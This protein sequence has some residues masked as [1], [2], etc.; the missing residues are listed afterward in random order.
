MYKISNSYNFISSITHILQRENKINQRIYNVGKKVFSYLHRNQTASAAAIWSYLFIEVGVVASQMMTS[1]DSISDLNS[2]QKVLCAHWDRDIETRNQFSSTVQFRCDSSSGI[3]NSL[4]PYIF[5][6]CMVDLCGYMKKI[7]KKFYSCMLHE[8]DLYTNSNISD[9]NATEHGEFTFEL[10]NRLCPKKKFRHTDILKEAAYMND[11]LIKLC[12]YYFFFKINLDKHVV[13]WCQNNNVNNLYNVLTHLTRLVH[14]SHKKS[15]DADKWM[16]T[17]VIA[18]LV[19][20]ISGVVV[21]IVS[22][23]GTIATCRASMFA[24]NVA[25]NMPSLSAGL[26]DMVSAAAETARVIL[27]VS[28]LP[29][30]AIIP[31][32]ALSTL[33]E[34]TESLSYYSAENF[35]IEDLQL[36]VIESEMEVIDESLKG[37]ISEIELGHAHRIAG[38]GIVAGLGTYGIGMLAVGSAK[39][40]EPVGKTVV[41]TTNIIPTAVT[42]KPEALLGRVVETITKASA[43][44]TTYTEQQPSSYR[45]PIDVNRLQQIIQEYSHHYIVEP[46]EVW[47][48]IQRQASQLKHSL[49]DWHNGFC[50]YEFPHSLFCKLPSSNKFSVVNIPLPELR[51][52][53][54]ENV[55]GLCYFFKKE[56]WCNWSKFFDI[57]A[58]TRSMS[59]DENSCPWDHLLLTIKEVIDGMHKID[60]NGG[61]SGCYNETVMIK[62]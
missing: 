50:Y 25:Q 46:S 62:V 61:T 18:T 20:A 27:E 21:G 16:K 13:D 59:R 51:E 2:C 4:L 33:S 54:S 5:S 47:N 53:F 7:G 41:K 11:C 40:L 17:N 49:Q 35:P 60:V 9:W 31:P 39:A 30:D 34:I 45:Q 44:F 42:V 15:E 56:L 1:E 57:M 26:K 36:N 14:E 29:G 58:T 8:A 55:L 12:N 22:V 32:E 43:A 6:T 37:S 23:I 38:G 52:A 48:I 19:A 10:W 28:S 24:S 3:E